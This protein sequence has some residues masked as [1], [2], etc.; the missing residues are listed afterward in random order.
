MSKPALDTLLNKA[1]D[2]P[3]SERAELA[4]DLLKSLDGAPDPNAAEAW[5]SEI[6]R[7]LD[8]VEDGTARLVDREEMRRRIRSR[9]AEA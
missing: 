8:Q 5:E 9:L 4:H 6:L 7:R 2:L 3:E 1:L